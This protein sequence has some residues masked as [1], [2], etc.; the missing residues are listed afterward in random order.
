MSMQFDTEQRQ[1]I[2]TVNTNILVSASAGA[3][4]TGVLVARFIKRCTQDHIPVSRILAMTFTSA[5]AAEMKKRVAK[6]LHELYD[7]CSQPAQKKYLSEQLSGLDAC[8]ITTI[9][10]W[11]LTVI[12]KYCNVIGLDPAAADHVLDDSRTALLHNQAFL[13]TLKT[14]QDTQPEKLLQL[15]T[16][17][18]SSSDDFDSL[19]NIIQSINHQALSSADPDSWYAHAKN[20]CH[21]VQNMNGFKPEI[22]DG[23]FNYLKLQMDIQQSYLSKMQ[24]AAEDGP[25]C[26]PE[27]VL[28]QLALYEPILEAL[29]AHDY[30]SFRSRYEAVMMHTTAADGKNKPYSELRKTYTDKCKKLFGILYS[31]NVFVK[32]SNDLSEICSMLVEMASDTEKQFQKLKLD[33]CSIDY[34]DMERYAYQILTSG[35]KEIAELVRSSFDEIMIDEFQDTS[36]LQ[37]SIIETIAKKDNVFRV[38]DVKQSIYR[39]RNAKPQLMRRLMKEPDNL[40]IQLKHNY[41]SSESIIRF[42]NLLFSKAMNVP[43]CLDTYDEEDHVTY[44][45]DEQKDPS[46]IPVQAVLLRNP[47]P[48]SESEDSNESEESLGSKQMKAEWIAKEI[49]HIKQKNPDMHYRDFAV[50]FRNHADKIPMSYALDALQIPYDLDAREGFYHSDLCQTVLAIC[51]CICN[52]NDGISLLVL[53]TSPMYGLNDEELAKMK[54]DKHSFVSGVHKFMPGVFEQ[55]K[56]L[57]GIASASAISS[58]LSAIAQQNDFYEKLDERSQANFD[59]LFQKTVSTPNISIHDFI[60]SIE[61]SDTEKSN[62]A[63]SKGADDDTVTITTIHQSKGL[64]YRYVFLWGSSSNRFMDS[65]SDV[66]VDDSLYLGMNHYDLP[67]RIS[68]PTVQRIA[69]QYKSDTADLEEFTRLVYVAMTRAEEKMYLVDAVKKEYQ[70]QDLS[71]ALLSQRNGITGLVLSCLSESE[72]FHIEYID[73][74]PI[75]TVFK[76]EKDNSQALPHFTAD[77]HA[78]PIQE[79]PSSSEMRSLPDLNPKS[80]SSAEHGTAIHECIASLP[81][82]TWTEEDLEP[83]KLSDYDQKKLLTFSSSSIYAKCLDKDIRK[84]M[85]F[86]V[87]DLENNRTLVGSMDFAAIGEADI[88]LIDFKTDAADAEQLK[89]RYA[90]QLHAYK[91]ALHLLWPDKHVRGYLYSFHLDNYVEIN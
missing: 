28:I 37:N 26:T 27:D 68:R 66:L 56:N 51:K 82:R 48:D 4:K 73:A 62:E 32:D 29:E 60:S 87:D 64:Q 91:R 59:F 10:S 53:L 8:S 75:K 81:N 6:E 34:D 49:Q 47:E 22:L 1:A 43:G 2:E 21:P 13:N 40:L 15:H 88:I 17:S 41:R 39:F 85:P 20:S 5:A 31:P 30:E 50:L 90:E 11:C 14:Y 45:R 84:E 24:K 72:L 61:A 65:R 52:P 18:T 83:Y 12:K 80:S 16:Y 86:F 7:T 78:Y 77:V 36:E 9:D 46:P 58:V 54:Q 79:S 23:F 44:G 63:M 35:S 71:L 67:Y 19:Q 76:T 25:K 38:G 89:Q 70:P 57:A 69:V 33:D 55:L 74:A 3:G 42:C